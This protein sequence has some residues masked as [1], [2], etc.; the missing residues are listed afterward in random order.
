MD[1]IS[2]IGFSAHGP[3]LGIHYEV[4][5]Q[6]NDG[7]YRVYADREDGSPPQMTYM[8]AVPKEDARPGYNRG[9]ETF[10]LDWTE[11]REAFFAQMSEAMNVLI[12]RIA[13][14]LL[15]D[16]QT[17]VDRMIAGGGGLLSLPAPTPQLEEGADA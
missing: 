2:S 9:R 11:E 17:T 10:L 4:M 14:M 3:A 5:W 13:A 1:Q 12:E 8:K 15:G 7:L 6:I 16:L